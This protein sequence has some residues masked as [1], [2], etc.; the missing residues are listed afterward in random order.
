MMPTY[1]DG[2][3]LLIRTGSV[4]RPDDVVVFVNPH[5]PEPGPPLLVKRVAAIGGDEIP[6]PIRTRIDEER[7]R[8]GQIVVLGDAAASLD[9]RM[10]GYVPAD[11]V[12]GV[13]LR[14]LER[15]A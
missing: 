11:S 9:S 4:C 15:R 13:V 6:Q 2:D 10:F 5:G 8:S 12:I 1:R 3:R 14:Q 7:V